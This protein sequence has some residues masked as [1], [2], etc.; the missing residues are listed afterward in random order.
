MSNTTQHLFTQSID[1][2]AFSPAFQHTSRQMGF[3]TL[4]EIVDTK[5]KTLPGNRAFNH[6]WFSELVQFMAGQNIL[7]LLEAEGRF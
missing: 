6:I 1:T 4:Q 5:E 7:D 3:T 2:L